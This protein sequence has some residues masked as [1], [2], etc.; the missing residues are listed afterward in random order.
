[1][2][3]G[4]ATAGTNVC[5][6][7]RKHGFGV[8]RIAGR[9]SN[10][11][12]SR[13]NSTVGLEIPPTPPSSPQRNHCPSSTSSPPFIRGETKFWNRETFQVGQLSRSAIDADFSRPL[14]KFDVEI[15]RLTLLSAGHP[16]RSLFE[17]FRGENSTARVS[18]SVIYC[19][20]LGRNTHRGT[21]SGKTKLGRPKLLVL[22]NQ[23]QTLAASDRL[24]LLSKLTIS[25]KSL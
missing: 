16:S 2:S 24:F 23:L 14:W 22:S 6:L 15:L 20:E 18:A 9:R 25:R 13:R 10:P 17:C 1:M 12:D 3:F 11:V 5:P 19:H 8:W 21:T 7:Q 4:R